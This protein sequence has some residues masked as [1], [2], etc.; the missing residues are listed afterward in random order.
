MAH[1][2]VAHAVDKVGRQLV[3]GIEQGVERC[4]S[5]VDKGVDHLAALLLALLGHYLADEVV[6]PVLHLLE[7]DFVVGVVGLCHT[8]HLNE[9]V[10]DSA[11]GRDHHNHLLRAGSHNVLDMVQTLCRT[12]RGAPEFHDFHS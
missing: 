9:L 4:Q 5:L 3:V 11:Q 10:G 6:V 1:D 8:G 7:H 2:G 12:Y